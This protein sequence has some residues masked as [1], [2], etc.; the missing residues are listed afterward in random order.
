MFIFVRYGISGSGL[1][2]SKVVPTW[3]LNPVYYAGNL[4]TAVYGDCLH[5]R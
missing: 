3:C 5:F 4:H 2:V 1:S